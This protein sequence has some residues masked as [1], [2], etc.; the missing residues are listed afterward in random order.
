MDKVFDIEPK[1]LAIV[2]DI[3]RTHLAGYEVRAFGSR[4]KGTARKFSDLDLVVMSEQP[5]SLLLFA[6]VEEAFSESGLPYKVDLLDWA[7]ISETFREII[8]QKYVVVSE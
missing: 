5:L 7:T 1:H 3:L 4:V 6:E 2:Q 8:S